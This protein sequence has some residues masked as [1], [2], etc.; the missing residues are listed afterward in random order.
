MLKLCTIVSIRTSKIGCGFRVY[1][2]MYLYVRLFFHSFVLIFYFKM[3]LFQAK[4][5]FVLNVFNI[6]LLTVA[7]NTWGTAYFGLDK[8]PDW[9]NRSSVV[10]G[11]GMFNVTRS[12]KFNMTTPG[13]V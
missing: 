1:V 2:E 9:G 10:S 7:I 8:F 11:S 3:A 4:A 13:Y 6:M 12:P 5:G